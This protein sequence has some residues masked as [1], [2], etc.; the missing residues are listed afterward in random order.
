MKK[1]KTNQRAFAPVLVIVTILSIV[2]VALS[3]Y[4]VVANSTAQKK[5]AKDAQQSITN[6]KSNDEKDAQLDTSASDSTSTSS[7]SPVSPAQSPAPAQ[8]KSSSQ[9][10]KPSVS[11]PSEDDKSTARSKI[12]AIQS[13]L[14]VY[15]VE[16]NYYPS[17]INPANFPS[18]DPSLYTPPP[19]IR[20][21]YTPSP[22]GCSTAGHNCTQYKLEAVDNN[23]NIIIA[24]ESF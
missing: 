12:Q 1:I 11:Q 15:D 16:N 5:A 21:V 10:T 7:A 6:A 17:D 14:E 24:K 2:A 4:G 3:C 9:S 22:S 23:G 18:S 19:N 13:N 8:A 20:F